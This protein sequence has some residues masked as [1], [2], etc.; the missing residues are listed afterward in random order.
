MEDLFGH[1][2]VS[3]A[4][5]LL[6]AAQ[7][8]GVPYYGCFSGGKDSVV[9]KELARLAGANVVWHY[10]VTTVDPPELIYFIR[11]HHADVVFH[12]TIT[13]W[14]LIETQGFPIRQ[15][16]KCCTALKHHGG[17]GHVKI[18]GIRWEESARRRNQWE[19]VS[20]RGICP[21]LQWNEADVW[22]FID[23]RGLPYCKLYDEGF[24]RL[25]CIGC[26]EA[27]VGQRKRDFA[28]WPTY[29][30]AYRRAFKRLWDRRGDSWRYRNL[31]KD[32]DALFDWWVSGLSLPEAGGC[33]LF[34]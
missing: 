30:N 19:A 15:H 4:I 34:A 8:M 16:K 12:R 31:F 5:E 32:S 17:D 21:I 23:G 20:E 13:M 14:K 11:E 33:G 24:S 7:P 26:P 27:G 9:I 1:D 22:E 2:K 28:R 29:E 10:N 18:L 3:D 25:G 6:R